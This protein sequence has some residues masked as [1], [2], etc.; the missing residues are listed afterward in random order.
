MIWYKYD[1]VYSHTLMSDL[2]QNTQKC[3]ECVVYLHRMCIQGILPIETLL[4]YMK[5]GFPHYEYID[6]T[7]S[8]PPWWKILMLPTIS[9]HMTNQL[10]LL[11]KRILTCHMKLTLYGECVRKPS[12]YSK[13]WKISY[14]IWTH[15]RAPMWGHWH[16]WHLSYAALIQQYRHHNILSHVQRGWNPVCAIQMWHRNIQ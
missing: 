4:N 6:S 5:T 10:N 3:T 2:T 8:H 14:T 12:R 13:M 7:W 16:V 9:L 11:G 1:S 15:G